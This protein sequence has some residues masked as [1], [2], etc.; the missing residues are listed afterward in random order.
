VKNPLP[1]ATAGNS[2][3]PFS[4][5]GQGQQSCRVKTCSYDEAS[6]EQAGSGLRGGGKIVS[7][8]QYCPDRYP[9]T[10]NPQG[11][12]PRPEDCDEGI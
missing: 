10:C 7:C 12:D 2:G 9:W 6:G 1:L 4:C 11:T 8:S 5:T 3:G